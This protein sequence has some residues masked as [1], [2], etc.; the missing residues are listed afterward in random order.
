MDH[1]RVLGTGGE[2]LDDPPA[3]IGPV[4]QWFAGRGR[5]HNIHFRN[6]V[7]RRGSFR[8]AFPVGGDMDM[9][10]PLRLLARSGY[11]QMVMP[12]HMPQVPG[13]DPKGNA[14]GCIA[15]RL[16]LLRSDPLDGGIRQ[17]LSRSRIASSAALPDQSRPARA[18]SAS[19]ASYSPTASGC[20]G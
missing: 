6:I 5:I 18:R 11:A 12:D 17:T 14:Y 16:Q 7:G 4:G 20:S 3:E 1:T 2:T 9:W 8:D 19:H 10:A 13:P 15:A